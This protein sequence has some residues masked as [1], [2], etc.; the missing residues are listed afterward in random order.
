[1]NSSPISISV[2]MPAY[3]EEL[4]IR[5]AVCQ[6]IDTFS[7]RELEF[8]ILIVDDNSIDGT[9]EIGDEL[10]KEFPTVHCIHHEKNEGPGGAFKTGVK[11]ATKDFLIFVPFDNPLAI[12]DLD[13]YLPRLG[14]C[15]IIVGVRVSREGYS[16]FAHFAS[17]FYNR[18]MIPL[19]FNIGVSD[20]NWIQIYRRC[21]FE[22]GTLNISSTKIFFLVEI[23]VQAKEKQLIVA[24]IPSRMKKR[25]HGM[26]TCSKFSTIWVTFLDA[27]RF[28]WK[29]HK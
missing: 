10:A 25:L 23:L 18:I 5:S 27:M 26:P 13:A 20:V 9:R 8:E 28:F 29:I 22:D 19:L 4:S 3:N 11:H 14:I 1:M 16:A 2:I 21:Y 24:E 12:E 17:F 6:N 7:S 15:D